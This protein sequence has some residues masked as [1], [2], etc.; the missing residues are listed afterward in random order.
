LSNVLYKTKIISSQEIISHD[1]FTFLI[2]WFIKVH[3]LLHFSFLFFSCNLCICF[4][5]L[6]SDN[7]ST[8]NIFVNNLLKNNWNLPML[9]DAY[10]FITVCMFTCVKFSMPNYCIK[11]QTNVLSVSHCTFISKQ[12]QRAAVNTIV[13]NWMQ[14]L[15]KYSTLQY[16]KC[17]QGNVICKPRRKQ[18]FLIP[19]PCRWFGKK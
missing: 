12:K 8:Q 14:M 9:L 19:F 1:F 4:F 13:I 5:A 2:H 11:V 3:F 6:I 15:M 7:F 10:Y 16:Y 18:Y 17:F